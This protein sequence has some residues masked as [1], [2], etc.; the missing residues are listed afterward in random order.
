MRVGWT[1]RREPLVPAAVAGAG[2]VG[3]A[4]L[5]GALTRAPRPRGIVAGD[6]VVLL[7]GDLPWADGALWLG[8]PDDAP[9]VYLPTRLA[10]DVH[11]ALLRRALAATV[12]GPV[13]FLPSAGVLVPLADARPVDDDGVREVLAR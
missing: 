6:L 4:L 5:R 10:P 3:R 11:P 2:D 1:A 8:T 9:G 13:A 12:D 7:G